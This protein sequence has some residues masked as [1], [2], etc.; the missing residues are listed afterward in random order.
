M[1]LS[2][3][4][5]P[6]DPLYRTSIRPSYV[7]SL[8]A[9]LT[10]CTKIFS[11]YTGR[12]WKYRLHCRVADYTNK[13]TAP[14]SSRYYAAL[15]STCK[16]A[17]MSTT[18]RNSIVFSW[19][20]IRT[21]VELIRCFSRHQRYPQLIVTKTD[22]NGSQEMCSMDHAWH[23]SNVHHVRTFS[24]IFLSNSARNPSE[25][26]SLFHATEIFCILL[27]FRCQISQPYSSAGKQ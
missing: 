20:P 8:P 11:T 12:C 18:G 1:K 9:S 17:L 19:I 13:Y 15:S 4:T 25:T 7:T 2:L 24:T 16:R 27:S 5:V 22:L 10:K 23:V 14:V 6:Q 21:Y 3:Q 26:V